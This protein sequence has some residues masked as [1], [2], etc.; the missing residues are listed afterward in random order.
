MKGISIGKDGVL[1]CAG[2]TAEECGDPAKPDDAIDFTF[3]PQPGE[4]YRLAFVS[5]HDPHSKVAIVL[6]PDP[7]EARDKGCTL[8]V[9]RLTPKF[10]LSYIT[11]SGFAPDSDVN[12]DTQSWDEKHQIPR[13]MD[14]EGKIDLV[15]L[16]GVVGH[17]R[18]T[19]TIKA[20]ATQCSP[21]LKFDWGPVTVR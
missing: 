20:L 9:V 15:M 11:G 10:E 19:T 18:G 16:N 17:D 7:I 4:P 5:E 12:F 13:R 14:A 6:V 21:S 8:S 2:R 3:Y 1:T